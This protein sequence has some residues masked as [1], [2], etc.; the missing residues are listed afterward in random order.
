[1]SAESARC[2]LVTGASGGI[3]KATA[4][5]LDRQGFRVFAGFRSV[6]AGESLKRVQLESGESLEAKTVIIATG[7]S[8]RMTGIPGEKELYG[9]KGVTTCAT[10][11]GAFYRKLEVAVIGGGVIGLDQRLV[12]SQPVRVAAV[13]LARLRD[14]DGRLARQLPERR[15]PAGNVETIRL[16][17]PAQWHD[18]IDRHR[19]LIFQ[20]RD[21]KLFTAGFFSQEGGLPRGGANLFALADVGQSQ[22]AGKGASRHHGG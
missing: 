13:K 7:A 14:A 12:L 4:L 8:P 17:R 19:R 16:D 2:V 20:G 18:R 15:Q 9:G 6:Q 21:A 22:W 11:D 3:G 5:L 10:C 1:M